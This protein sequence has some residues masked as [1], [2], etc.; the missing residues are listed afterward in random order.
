MPRKKG[1]RHPK[2]IYRKRITPKKYTLHREFLNGTLEEIHVLLDHWKVV[3][4]RFVRKENARTHFTEIATAPEWK[5][6]KINMKI[7][8]DKSTSTKR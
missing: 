6:T 3:G 4:Y 2:S 8:I 5:Q 7:Y 1:S